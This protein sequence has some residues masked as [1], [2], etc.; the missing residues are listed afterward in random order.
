MSKLI[1]YKNDT[2]LKERFVKEIKWH[3]EQDKFIKGTYSKGSGK[4]FI[5]ES[6]PSKLCSKC[7]NKLEPILMGTTIGSNYNTIP[8]YSF[9]HYCPKL[10]QDYHDRLKEINS[11]LSMPTEQKRNATI[12]AGYM[13]AWGS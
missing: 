11:S 9:G 3:K 2:K 12:A 10:N 4:N 1:S 5:N 6:L 13:N 7:G 8:H